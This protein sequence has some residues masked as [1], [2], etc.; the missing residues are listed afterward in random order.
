M[1][2]FPAFSPPF[3]CVP[4]DVVW[5]R[6]AIRSKEIPSC[7]VFCETGEHVPAR[8][9][10]LVGTIYTTDI[11]YGQITSGIVQTWGEENASGADEEAG[12][13]G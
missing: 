12:V 3:W 9:I 5:A 6:S 7:G 11:W 1:K 2:S 8:G 13:L 4:C 10:S